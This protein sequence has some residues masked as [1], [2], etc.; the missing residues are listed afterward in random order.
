MTCSPVASIALDLGVLPGTAQSLST[1]ASVMSSL[2]CDETPNKMSANRLFRSC[3]EK[4]DVGGGYGGLRGNRRSVEKTVIQASAMVCVTYLRIHLIPLDRVATHR[5]H[6]RG[7]PRARFLD[8]FVR[9]EPVR[10]CR[11]RLV[12]SLLD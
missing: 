1:V 3:E 7:E 11:V 10:R 6:W 2:V 5:V 8:D 4:L 12:K 9:F